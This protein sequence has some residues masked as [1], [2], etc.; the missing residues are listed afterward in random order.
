MNDFEIE[1]D[2]IVYAPGSATTDLCLRVFW[3][4]EFR[5]HKGGIKLYTLFDIETSIP[6]F[7]HIT[8]TRV[9]DDNIMD[10]IPYE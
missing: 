6:G 4:A 1:V 9:H 7:I 10:L 2:D 5:K 8:T 3:W